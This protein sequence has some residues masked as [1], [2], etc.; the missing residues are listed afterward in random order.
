M[1]LI[2]KITAQDL[3]IIQKDDKLLIKT[4]KSQVT[5]VTINDQE[6]TSRVK[7]IKESLTDIA[8]GKLPTNFM[9]SIQLCSFAAST[10]E[11]EQTLSCV[12]IK[13]D[14]CLASDNQRIARAH[15]IEPLPDEILLKAAEIKNLSAINPTDY[16]I[17][18]TWL[19]FKNDDGCIFSIRRIKGE[20]P[21]FNSILDFTGTEVDIPKNLIEGTDLASVFL[22]ADRPSVTVSLDNNFCIVSVRSEQ[23]SMKYRS[24]LNYKGEPITFEINP[25]F[26]EQMLLYST[27]MIIDKD[28]A[29]LETENFTLCTV[30]ISYKG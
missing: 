6:F 14:L 20:Y 2:T 23:G 1:H 27:K 21:D 10:S 18:K 15:L 16:S 4:K 11:T 9:K 28:K 24:K 29:K 26:L 5:L 8:W 19:H 25:H 17:T 3:N 22:D 30:L 13:G 12:Y 7:A